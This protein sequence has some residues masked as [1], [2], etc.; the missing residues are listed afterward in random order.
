MLGTSPHTFIALPNER[1]FYT[2]PARTTFALTS[3][4]QNPLNITS[5]AGVAI[6]TNQRVRPLAHPHYPPK[7][8]PEA[9]VLYLPT[10]PTPTFES[11]SAPLTHLLDSRVSAPFF[12]PNTWSCSVNPVASGGLP[13]ATSAI[14]MELVFKDGGAF[15]FSTIFERVRERV[16]QVIENG[17]GAAVHLED[18][19]TYEDSGPSPPSVDAHLNHGPVPA[20]APPGY[21]EVQRETVENAAR[22]GKV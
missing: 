10:T 9:Q 13:A 17:G 12:G 22:A 18:L 1:T 7:A 2:S 19:P 3:T 8:D 14:E 5:S 11:F 20:D 4:G 6:I 15:D 21:E 16:Q